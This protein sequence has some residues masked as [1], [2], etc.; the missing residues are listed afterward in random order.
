MPFTPSHVAAALPFLR[1]PLVPAALAVGTMAPDFPY[2]L[3]HRLGISRDDTHSLLGLVTVDLAMTLLAVAL[4]WYV[5]RE[6]VI[7]LLPAAVRERIPARASSSW[8]RE[9]RSPAIA[10]ALV[11]V[12]SIV[13][14]ATH[15]VWD[16]FTHPGWLVDHVALLRLRIGPLPVEKWLQHASTVAGLVVLAIWAVIRLR[17]TERDPHRPGR[18]TGRERVAWVTVIVLAAGLGGGIPWVIGLARGMSPVDPVLLFPVACL[19]VACGV[20]AVLLSAGAWHLRR[21]RA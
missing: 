20:A 13:G 18:F 15:L 12:S 14:G 6:A 7:D 9:R 2:Y 21:R 11:I 17:G 8:W 19:L 1:T 16:S 5:M 4:W 3:P 10:I